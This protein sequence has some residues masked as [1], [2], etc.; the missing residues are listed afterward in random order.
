MNRF[1]RY[2]TTP[3]AGEERCSAKLHG[4][5]ANVRQYVRWALCVSV[6]NVV[7]QNDLDWT[8]GSCS[9]DVLGQ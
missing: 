3:A 9:G 2:G 4:A 6:E 7:G 1:R 5:A 8:S